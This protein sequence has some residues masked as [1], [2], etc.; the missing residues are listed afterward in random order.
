[1]TVAAY[2][3]I[4]MFAIVVVL[5]GVGSVV[6]SSFLAPKHPTPAKLAPYECGIEPVGETRTERFPIK[7]YVIAMLFIIFDIETV[8]L[9]PWAVVFRRF[10]AAGLAEMG[11]FALFLFGA[12]VYVWKRKGLEWE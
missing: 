7:F 9:F 10:G 8:F 1:M 5:F 11:I 3:P 6:A 12:Y 2:L 4:L